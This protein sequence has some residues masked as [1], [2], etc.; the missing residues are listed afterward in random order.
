L[1]GG[2]DDITH[3]VGLAGRG[4]LHKTRLIIVRLAALRLSGNAGR[5][6]YC[7]MVSF[8]LSSSVPFGPWSLP[9]MTVAAWFGT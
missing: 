1:P 4:Q 7:L 9:G 8:F 3:Q 5:Q 6:C 2:V